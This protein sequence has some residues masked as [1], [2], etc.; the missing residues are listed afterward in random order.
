MKKKIRGL[1]VVCGNM[2][3]PPGPQQKKQYIDDQL[4]KLTES[5]NVPGKVFLGR[6]TGDLL[7]KEGRKLMESFGPI[8]DYDNLKRSECLAFGKEILKA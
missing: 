5:G 3:Q 1:W 7:D 8:V 4:A 2:Q 6:I